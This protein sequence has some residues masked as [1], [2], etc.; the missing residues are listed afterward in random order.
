MTAINIFQVHSEKDVK[1]VRELFWEYL[2]W[3]NDMNDQAFGI[4]LDIAT[5]LDE[6]MANLEKFMPPHG[7]LL[8]S[9]SI[10]FA[11]GCICLKK[12]SAS[13]GELK[14]LY[15]RPAYR[16][17]GIGKK[18]VEKVLDEARQIGY[19]TIRL[20]STKYMTE[21]HNLYRSFGFQEIEPYPESEIP[22]K[23]YA[24]WVF[25]E[26]QIID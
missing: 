8:L 19:E 4:R 10:G 24:H 26:N 25:M 16:G 20:D 12:L 2:T 7:R 13:I 3:A 18:M 6:D 15:V 11:A 5:M 22:E 21:A 17:K 9:E 1:I 23:Y 14:R